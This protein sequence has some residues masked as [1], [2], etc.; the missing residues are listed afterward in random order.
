MAKSRNRRR[1]RRTSSSQSWR[2]PDRPYRSIASQMTPAYD[3]AVREGADAELRGDAAEAFRLHRAVPMFRQSTHGDRLHQLAALGEHAP[4]WM[5]NRWLTIQARRPVWSGGNEAAANRALQLAVPLLYPDG[6]PIE[7]IGCAHVEQV[8]PYIY[9]R[10]W[11]ARQLDVYD[12]GGLRRVVDR[13]AS[14]ELLARSDQI[15]AWCDSRIRACRIERVDAAR[16]DP[17]RLVDLTSGEL[18]DTLD[19]GAPV[20]PGQHV[21]ARV[22]PTV[23]EPGLMLD[24]GLLPVSEPVAQAVAADPRRW[25]PTLSARIRSGDMAAGDSHLPEAALISD[26]PYRSWLSLVDVPLEECP[27]HDPAPLIAKALEHVVDLAEDGN[28]VGMGHRHAIG[29]L[30]LDPLL[31]QTLRWRFVAPELGSAWRVLSEVVPD[32][33][34]STCEEMALWCA[35][36]PEQPDAI[37]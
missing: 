28:L 1:S 19:L 5:I 36:A 3:R 27:D 35:A 23:A 17:M 31:D 8:L 34:R 6:I 26:L 4:G 16:H 24:W 10:D 15:Q 21:L 13:H 20:E 2:P 33:A 37:A 32:H 7:R 14:A 29:E 22:V 11:V 25:L 12:L 9:E 18:L 30:M